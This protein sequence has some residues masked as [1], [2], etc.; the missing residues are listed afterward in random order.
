MNEMALPSQLLHIHQKLICSFP[1]VHTRSVPFSPTRQQPSG[2]SRVYEPGPDSLS[3]GSGLGP[4]H[5]VYP[6]SRFLHTSPR[7][8]PCTASPHEFRITTASLPASPCTTR[9]APAVQHPCGR[10]PSRPARF[11]GY[12]PASPPLLRLPDTPSL[13]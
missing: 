4:F 5:L 7:A 12:R 6:H 10:A 9:E 13:C 2:C 11:G 3:S 1:S 8:C